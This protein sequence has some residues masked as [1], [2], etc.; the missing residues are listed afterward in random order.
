[1][2]LN[3]CSN[4]LVAVALT[5]ATA[6]PLT[7]S[8]EKLEYTETVVTPDSHESAAKASPRKSTATTAQPAA[9]AAEEAIQETG[10]AVPETV[11]SDS[12]DCSMAAFNNQ[13]SRKLSR[14]I[15]KL[16]S[17]FISL[18]ACVV[19][20]IIIVAMVL[21]HRVK[22]ERLRVGLF[23]R[24]I[25]ADKS[26]AAFLTAGGHLTAPRITPSLI[27]IGVGITGVLFGAAVE[28][29]VPAALSAFP[30]CI[31]LAKLISYRIDIKDYRRA[32]DLFYNSAAKSDSRNESS[33]QL[34]ESDSTGAFDS[35]ACIPD[36]K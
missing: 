16:I 31:G 34:H 28:E 5:T 26:I 36:R 32:V 11:Y 2:K 23:D 6:A 18:T 1:M 13:S 35:D 22:I 7:L 21:S 15:V 10:N 17:L 3:F 24:A 14:D 12:N 33:P 8:A 27:W 19:G 30:I 20:P 29:S 25:I 9:T 4:L